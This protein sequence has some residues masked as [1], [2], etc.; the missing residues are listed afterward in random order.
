M[1]MGCTAAPCIYKKGTTLDVLI[2]L[3]ASFDG[4]GDPRK[5]TS[6]IFVD[7]NIGEY[8][9]SNG[10]AVSGVLTKDVVVNQTYTLSQPLSMATDKNYD[11]HNPEDPDAPQYGSPTGPRDVEITTWMLNYELIKT[12]VSLAT[13][14]VNIV[15]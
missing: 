2:T 12:R 11:E 9:Q 14:K 10:Y 4:A 8:R 6:E 15:D 3:Q 7:L 5:K 13:F 1:T